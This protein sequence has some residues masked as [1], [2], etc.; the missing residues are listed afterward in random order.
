MHQG[1]LKRQST[2]VLDVAY[3]SWGPPS[4]PPTL[5]LHG[6][7]DDARS[8]E[9]VA[10]G[11]AGNGR[12]VIAPY[13]RGFGPTRFRGD[14]TPRSGQLAALVTDV[15]EFADALGLERFVL[16][17]HDWGARA[18]QGLAALY[19][20]RVE[21][22]VSFTDYEVAW[23]EGFPPYEALH[24]LWYQWVLLSDLGPALL[25]ADRR[26]F[27]RYLWRVW[28]PTWDFDDETF[29]ETAASFDNPDFVEVVLSAYRHGRHPGATH[30]PRYD[31]LEA[32]LAAGPEITV[33]TVLLIGADD[34]I[35]QPHP[36]DERWRAHFTGEARR[37]LLKGVGHFPHRERPQAVIEAV[38]TKEPA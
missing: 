13:L 29:G 27:C 21:R 31:G 12:R 38:L 32:R 17:G 24:A 28:S 19:P 8:W 33:P 37:H 4:G 10:E 34:G 23:G 15:L 26:G 14:R 6:F 30:D 5:L 35:V 20:E 22:L 11:L 9:R 2:S 36:G 25:H 16:V 3:L 7:P 18:A 1:E